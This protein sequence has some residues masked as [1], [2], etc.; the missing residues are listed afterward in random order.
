MILDGAT[1]NEELNSDQKITES[2]L[3]VCRWAYICFTYHEE[4]GAGLKKIRGVAG[5]P[6]WRSRAAPYFFHDLS[7]IMQ[8]YTLLQMAKLH[9]EAETYGKTNI[10]IH[11]IKEKLNWNRDEKQAINS[12][13]A[14]MTEFYKRIK[15]ARNKVIAHNDRNAYQD[16]HRLGCFIAEQDNEWFGCLEELADRV[17]QKFLGVPYSLSEDSFATTDVNEFLQIVEKGIF[18]AR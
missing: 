5:E 16:N 10:S 9:D 15:D 7:A 18:S 2:F 8:E 11:Y 6:R 1:M 17:S 14:K 12:I 13:V 3:E 4:I